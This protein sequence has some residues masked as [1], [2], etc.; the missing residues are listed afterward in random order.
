[1]WTRA[2]RRMT[3]QRQVI[4][5][6]LKKL[7]S[8]PTAEALHQLVRRRLPKISMATV[9]RNLEVLCSEGLAQKLDM[10]GAQRRF[11]GDTS[12]HYHVRCVACG[13]VEDVDFEPIPNIEQ[14][15]GDRCA[16]KV[17][18]HRLEFIGLCPDC[19]AKERAEL[20]I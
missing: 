9:Y 12:N 15:I 5:E 3:N 19:L 14:T 11:D 13:R 1:M 6:E 16:Y 10:S 7:R 2:V 18:S 17:L 8:H 20:G 4:L